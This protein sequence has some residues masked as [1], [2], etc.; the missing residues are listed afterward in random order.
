MDVAQMVT[1][2]V[3]QAERVIN[4]THKP[5][6]QEFEMIAKATALGMAVVGTMGL[7]ISMVAYYLKHGG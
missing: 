3:Q 2:F 1:D 7:F 5:R 4:V 6:R